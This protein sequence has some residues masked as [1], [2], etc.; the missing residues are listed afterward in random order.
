MREPS[1]TEAYAMIRLL[2]KRAQPGDAQKIEAL[3]RIIDDV[4]SA[5]A[6]LDLDRFFSSDPGAPAAPG[7][8]K[9]K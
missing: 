8:R 4:R 5:K 6:Q 9:P 7:G 3:R 2:R 1:A